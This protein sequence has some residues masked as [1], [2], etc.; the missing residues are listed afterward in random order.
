MAPKKPVMQ[1]DRV[2]LSF[3]KP[4]AQRISATD[5]FQQAVDVWMRA[6]AVPRIFCVLGKHGKAMCGGFCIQSAEALLQI[7]IDGER[8]LLAGLVFDRRDNDTSRVD[9]VDASEALD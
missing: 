8:T 7:P 5:D 1:M 6:R 3:K 9:K 2:F 4:Y